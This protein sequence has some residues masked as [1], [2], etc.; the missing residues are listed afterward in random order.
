MLLIAIIATLAGTS[1]LGSLRGWTIA[2][3]IGSAFALVGLALAGPVGPAWPLRASMFALGL[4]NGA[5]AVAAI[6]SM[7]ALAGTGDP[8]RAGVRMGLWG[9]AQALAFAA[10]GVIAT[11]AVDLARHLL[12][13]PTAA[14]S[15]VFAGEAILFLYASGLAARVGAGA[16]GLHAPS[17]AALYENPAAEVRY[18]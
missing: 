1:R 11:G 12:G 2:G 8:S 7:M 6:G 18:G 13:A 10:G 4:A 5:F 3:C 17:L 15:M 14:Y 16:Q 9:A